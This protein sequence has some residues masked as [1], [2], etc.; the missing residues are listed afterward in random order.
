M[1]CLCFE[2][3]MEKDKQC[4][5]MLGTPVHCSS[6]STPTTHYAAL[7]NSMANSSS[8][9]HTPIRPL[10]AAYRAATSDQQVSIR[11]KQV[12]PVVFTD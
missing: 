9:K 10:T 2:N 4:S 12:N 3:V 7:D 5:S 6:V 8:A 1:S 11:L